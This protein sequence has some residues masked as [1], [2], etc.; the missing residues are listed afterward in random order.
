[1]PT[2]IPSSIRRAFS[3]R[4]RIGL[5]LVGTATVPFAV[6]PTF[7]NLW[8]SLS[9][10]TALYTVATVL[11][12]VFA[13][14]TWRSAEGSRMD[15][16]RPFVIVS[17]EFELRHSAF[18]EG[19]IGIRN[20]GPGPALKC[21]VSIWLDST[22]G[23]NVSPN[24]FAWLRAHQLHTD[25]THFMEREPDLQLWA[26]ALGPNSQETASGES[27]AQEGSRRYIRRSGQV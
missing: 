22:L 9:Y 8:G 6:V 13:F 14:V 18:I 11:I 4:W 19:R 12:A 1:M 23:A 16:L 10:W 17:D 5:V 3:Q 26:N 7:L 24:E 27:D 21:R 25:L 20:V 15:A 2:R